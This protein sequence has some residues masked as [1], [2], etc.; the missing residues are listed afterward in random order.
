MPKVTLN[1]TQGILIE[2]GSG[3]KIANQDLTLAGSVHGVIKFS[4][5]TA[6]GAGTEVDTG[7]DLPAGDILIRKVIVN[8]TA[9]SGGSSFDLGL[10]ST[11]TG[12]DADALVDGAGAAAANIH[13]PSYSNAHRGALAK[14]SGNG[15]WTGA[16]LPAATSA[17][18]ISFTPK[19]GTS[20]G[21]VIIEYTVL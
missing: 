5:T 19:S 13:G 9:G 16:F 20:A 12:G 7:L 8:V 18:S 10:L 2:P 14:N 11:E 21:D 15:F 4:W 3:V 6:N 1:N 17:R